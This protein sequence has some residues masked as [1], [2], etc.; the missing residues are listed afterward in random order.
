MAKY[1][2]EIMEKICEA[3][4]KGY[5]PVDAAKIYGVGK[6]TYYDWINDERKPEFSDAIKKADIDWKFRLIEII[7]KAANK[8]W[9][10]AAWLLERI[11]KEEFSLRQENHN[12]GNITVNW[13]EELTNETDSE[14]E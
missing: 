13:H 10:A 3:I 12:T 6:S 9:T 5:R 1:S 8:T 14:T 7:D 4:R 11:Y 2:P